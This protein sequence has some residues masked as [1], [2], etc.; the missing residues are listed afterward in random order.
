MNWEMLLY[1]L[2][3]VVAQGEQETNEL[4]K[5]YRYAEEQA[6]KNKAA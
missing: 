2:R 1:F 4:M 3:R 5:L 6:R